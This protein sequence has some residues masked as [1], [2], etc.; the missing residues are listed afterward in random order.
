MKTNWLTSVIVAIVSLP[1]VDA[2]I[3]FGMFAFIGMT[4]REIYLIVNP[5]P[6]IP[7]FQ[8]SDIIHKNKSE[9]LTIEER[10]RI[11]RKLSRENQALEDFQP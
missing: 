6:V 2:L 9:N 8:E 3:L 5:K 4:F 11:R 10:D 1:M 7:M